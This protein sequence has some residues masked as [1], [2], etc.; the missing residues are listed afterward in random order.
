MRIYHYT[1]IDVL[2][3]ILKN[4]TIRF[5]RLDNVDDP[6]E[7]GFEID[8]LNPAKYTYV[9]CW[10]RNSIESIPQWL[11][12]GNK[13][14]G[15]RLSFDSDLFNIKENQVRNVKEWFTNE[16]MREWDYMIMP[17]LNNRILYDIQYVTNPADYKKNIFVNINEETGIDMKEVGVYKKLDWAFQKECRYTI[18]AFPKNAKGTYNH[19]SFYLENNLYCSNKYIDIPIKETAL[20]SIEIVLGPDTTEAERIL[21]E[22]LCYRFIGRNVIQDSVFKGL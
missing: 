14:H 18:Q 6:E 1:S 4:R 12:Y 17:I 10:T 5:T 19:L 8:G 11:I 22:S 21:V 3:L 7:Y 9:S 15:V 20:N 2:A 16:E 13:R